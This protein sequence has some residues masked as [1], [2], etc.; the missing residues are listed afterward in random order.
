MI[1][2]RLF[3]GLSSDR[4]CQMLLPEAD[5][6]GTYKF[7]QALYRAYGFHSARLNRFLQSQAE[8]IGRL[9][10]LGAAP[11][12]AAGAVMLTHVLTARSVAIR[13]FSAPRCRFPFWSAG[14]SVLLGRSSR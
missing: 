7:E 9:A 14:T 10:V 4:D 5:H 12:L 6:I 3:G 11:A 2:S 8:L 13:A 1:F